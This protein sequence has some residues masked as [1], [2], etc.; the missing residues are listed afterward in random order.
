M[1]DD[2]VDVPAPRRRSLG[3]SK[4]CANV[5]LVNK[6]RKRESSAS[7]CIFFSGAGVDIA[8]RV[9][10]ER[11]TVGKR[12]KKNVVSRGT[13]GLHYHDGKNVGVACCT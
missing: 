2:D 12:S 1:D 13:S 6:A 8:S 9:E 11:R 5:I 3:G 10:D 4:Q 7:R